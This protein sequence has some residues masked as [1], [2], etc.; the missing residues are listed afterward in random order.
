ME[1]S[2]STG[3]H[4]TCLQERGREPEKSATL[5]L[6]RAIKREK[7]ASG[8]VHMKKATKDP[9]KRDWVTEE[10]WKE[11][12]HKRKKKGGGGHG[13]LMRNDEDGPRGPDQATTGH[14]LVDRLTPNERIEVVQRWRSGW[15]LMST[16]RW[17]AYAVWTNIYITDQNEFYSLYIY[18][19]IFETSLVNTY[20]PLKAMVVSRWLSYNGN[21]LGLSCQI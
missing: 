6:R 9:T 13:G 16:F 15:T 3:S 11:K 7:R 19:Y 18:I 5:G 4:K 17:F 8:K 12:R 10:G 1:I 14:D 20:G 21:D 2:P